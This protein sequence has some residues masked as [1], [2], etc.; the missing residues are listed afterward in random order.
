MRRRSDR[1][2]HESK[3]RP[4]LPFGKREQALVVP[5]A[6]AGGAPLDPT[7]KTGKTGETGETDRLGIIHR[8]I[9]FAEAVCHLC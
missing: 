4:P 8:I 6:R 2:G 5:A 7:P 9:S 1:N 3:Q